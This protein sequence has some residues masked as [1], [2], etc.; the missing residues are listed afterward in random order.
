MI[1]TLIKH[2]REVFGSVEKFSSWLDTEN[3]FFDKKT[4]SK[5]LTTSS[6]LKFV[7]DRLTAM[8]YGDNV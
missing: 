7:D 5:F 2:G 4:P 3:F 1:L 8:E 6:G